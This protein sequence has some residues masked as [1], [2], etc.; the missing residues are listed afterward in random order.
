MLLLRFYDDGLAQASYLIGC[1]TTGEALVV[2]PNRD[3]EQ[4]IAAAEAEGLRIAHVTE[5][6]I[7]ADFVSGGRELAQRTGATLYLSDTGGPDWRYAYAAQAGAVLLQDG[8]SFRVGNVAIEAMHTPGHTPEHLAYLVTDTPASSAPLGVLS[9]DFVFVSDV[10][11]PDLLER[12]ANYRGTMVTGARHLFR[13]LQRFKQLPD[14]LQIWPGHGAGSACGK[15]LGAMPQS[16]LGYERLA[17]WAFQVADEDAFVATVLE[18]QPEPPRYFAEMKRINKEGP[19]ILGGLGRPRRIPA[20]RIGELLVGGAL[21]L[22][23][24]AAA[25]YAAA[26]VPGTINIPLNRAFTGWAGW[27]IP[28]DRDFY[29]M[30]DRTRA[31]AVET[32]V[33][34]LAMIGLDRL[35]GYLD[36]DDEMLEAWRAAGGT[37]SSTVQRTVHQVR[38]LMRAGD[39]T[40]IDVRGRN[41]WEAGHLPGVV[42]IPLGLLPDRLAELPTQG[43]IVLQCQTGS[44]S[45]IA[46]SLLEARGL[47]AVA[48][49]EGGFAAWRQAGLPVVAEP[50]V[51]APAPA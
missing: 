5:T 23:T 16:T 13:S 22:D 50:P 4:Y 2:D 46:A 9:G 19:R 29:L 30:I 14:H 37:V 28:Y 31:D 1:Q 8:R 11:R 15:A 41:E 24:R 48:N 20:A 6:H 47:T 10:G 44:R 25:D 36:C 43:T 45:A 49:L 18:G 7:H 26:H 17:N 21:V 27:L 51:P 32:A 42:N 39:V 38:E 34:D 33:R 3:V 12:A 40:V 35:T